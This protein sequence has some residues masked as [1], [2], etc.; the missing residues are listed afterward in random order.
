MRRIYFVALLSLISLN[1]FAQTPVMQ[2]SSD[3]RI[4]SLTT[5]SFNIA[6]RNISAHI[7]SWGLQS[8]V[9]NSCTLSFQTAPAD[10]GPWIEQ[11]TGDCTS[12]G[13]TNYLVF[14]TN[15]IRIVATTF[16]VQSGNALVTI[17]YAGY[18]IAPTSIATI[19]TAPL[20]NQSLNGLN[21]CDNY[22]GTV[23]AKWN[24]CISA[25]PAAGGL[26]LMV[27]PATGS[28]EPTTYP[29]NGKLTLDFR[30]LYDYLIENATRVER[31]PNIGIRSDATTLATKTLTGTI[32]LTNGATTIYGTGTAFSSELAYGSIIR[33]VADA[34]TAWARVLSITDNTNATLE[35]N[36]TGTGGTGAA[37]LGQAN[38]T[39]AMR[40][41]VTG[42]E[43]NSAAAGEVVPLSIFVNRT[44]GSRQI[45]GA[46]FNV[47]FNAKT[48][49]ASVQEFDL[50]NYSGVDWNENG[51]TFNGQLNETYALRINSAGTALV[52]GAIKC[53]YG[54]TGTGFHKCLSMD[55]SWK[56]NAIFSKA[57]E[58][59]STTGIHFKT[60]PFADDNN[61]SFVWRNS[62]NNA[63]I[64]AV[65]NI[66]TSWWRGVLGAPAGGL[67]LPAVPIHG[68]NLGGNNV[69]IA[70]GAEN[71]NAG[72]GT[73]AIGFSATNTTF[74]SGTETRSFK[75]AIGL[76][77]NSSN[78]RGNLEF[79][80]RQV[81]DTNNAQASDRVAYFNTSGVFNVAASISAPIL[82]ATSKVQIAS[83]D[84]SSAPRMTWSCFVP[85]SLTITYTICQF[86]PDKAITITRAQAQVK[87]AAVGCLTNASIHVESVAP[88]VAIDM[89]VGTSNATDSGAV[90]VNYAAGTVLQITLAQA[91]ATCGT[92]PQDMNVVV[93]YKMQ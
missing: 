36:Y 85:N 88:V 56:T 60:V 90:S 93:Q 39:I 26:G 16:N 79:F 63:N 38:L 76:T 50:N 43:P 57:R 51:E 62:G 13:T 65:Y 92:N 4:G 12:N 54:I 75:A 48:R 15:W 72:T 11:T 34:E 87:I 58:S 28:G 80:N 24:A 22:S 59:S 81:N 21:F 45:F 83:E 86:T 61:P 70:V 18:I 73:G 89:V 40:S 29:S 25:I 23:N 74:S 91:A 84:V 68:Y 69:L 78:G 20:I 17:N 82:T 66:G 30:R 31:P 42:G 47:S 1:L 10:T 14:A 32:T 52:Q 27:N 8:G 71:D 44:S 6:N 46:N 37:V 19:T 77:R 3:I 2:R 64:A 7:F 53:D 9:M 35:N 33:L 41:N 5:P 49:G 55:S 67:T